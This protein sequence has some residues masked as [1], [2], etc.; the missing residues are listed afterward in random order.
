LFQSATIS[1]AAV[2][3]AGSFTIQLGTKGSP[4]FALVEIIRASAATAN[5]TA[6]ITMSSLP[7]SNPAASL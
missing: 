1:I 4:A 6:S 7:G 3:L 2:F 5:R